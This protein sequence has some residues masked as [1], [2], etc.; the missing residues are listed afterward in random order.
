MHKKRYA[1]NTYKLTLIKITTHD[2]A[3]QPCIKNCSKCFLI[4]IKNCNS[5]L[6]FNEHQML[7]I[8]LGVG[9][10]NLK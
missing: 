5:N 4:V 7:G 2:I 3:T 6:L 10:N 9:S 8:A 1:Q